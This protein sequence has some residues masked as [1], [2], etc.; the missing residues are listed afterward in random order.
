ME[1]IK[2]D[3]VEYQVPAQ[4][5]ASIRAQKTRIDAA[6]SALREQASKV[7]TAEA[8]ADAATARAD[9]ASA[10]LAKE[11]KARLDAGE[12]AKAEM[13]ARIDLERTAEEV[14]GAGVKLDG[15]KDSEI[16]LQVLKRLDESADLAGKSEA[17]LAARFDIALE[18]YRAENP[19]LDKVREAAAAPGRREDSADPRE[20]FMRESAAGYQRSLASSIEE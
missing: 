13:R 9:A 6:E 12:T 20:K 5:A 10:D 11:K 1:T 18:S 17:Y 14:L 15:L 16:K 7:A 19:A 3:G 2:I 8:K 4:V